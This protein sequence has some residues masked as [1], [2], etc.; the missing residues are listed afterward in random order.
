[1]AI[2]SVD[3]FQQIS[4]QVKE[5]SA[6]RDDLLVP[7][8]DISMR[9]G[10]IRVAFGREDEQLFEPTDWATGQLCTRLGIPGPYFKKCPSALQDIQF[11]Y[12]LE[13]SVKYEQET[14][15]EASHSGNG[16]E[17]HQKDRPWLLRTRGEKLRAVLSDRY[18]AID[19]DA[20]IDWCLL[21][22]QERFTVASF[23]LSEESMHL[24]LLQKMEPYEVLPDDPYF[25]GLHIANSEVG[26]RSV[27]IDAVL[28]RLVCTNGLLRPIEGDRLLR[29]RHVLKARGYVK[30]MLLDGIGKSLNM[31]QS[32]LSELTL[33]ART[34][35]EGIEATI[36]R[37][38]GQWDLSKTFVKLAVQAVASERS[39][40]QE[41]LYG[42]LNGLT[43]AAQ[44]LG[45]DE[46]YRVEAL[47]GSLLD[48][49]KMAA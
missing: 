43:A 10:A 13:E 29:Q 42:L 27:S 14:K 44:S 1:M 47:A 6:G 33:A 7:T 25:F 12:W 2:Q 20:I 37:L 17:P 21:V 28:Y 31:A 9:H 46:R 32:L 18:V 19:N 45:S 16:T 36:T 30:D 4:S 26:K 5:S 11:N 48:S 24:R 39:A 34:P 41:T 22:T 8:K 49:R 40:Y 38:A 35:V 23:D 15:D 3:A